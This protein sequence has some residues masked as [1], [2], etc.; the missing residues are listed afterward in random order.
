MQ[1]FIPSIIAHVFSG[2]TIL[3]VF[4][5]ILTNLKSVLKYKLFDKI[6]IL[7]L[8]SITIGIHSLS[9]LG[10]ETKHSFIKK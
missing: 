5:L 8:F 3:V 7:L 1:Y 4:V 6:V 2:L 10:L 9:H